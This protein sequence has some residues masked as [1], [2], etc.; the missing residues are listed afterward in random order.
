MK[1]TRIE[2]KGF[3]LKMDSIMCG[4]LNG[5]TTFYSSE[6]GSAF[7]LTPATLT[8]EVPIPERKVE[9]TESQLDA[10][11]DNDK[12]RYNAAYLYVKNKLF[13]EVKP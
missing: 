7:P 4:G 10:L 11:F 12:D 2:L 8:I 9:I 6:S 3:V 13:G 5:H 1:T